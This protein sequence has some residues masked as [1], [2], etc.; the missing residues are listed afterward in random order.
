V[1]RGSWVE[2]QPVFADPNSAIGRIAD[3]LADEARCVWRVF[4]ADEVTRGRQPQSL[5]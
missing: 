5:L 3:V 4:S 1:E 2:P